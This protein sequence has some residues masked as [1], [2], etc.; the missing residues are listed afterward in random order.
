LISGAV[1]AAGTSSRM[2]VDKQTALLAGRPLIEYSIDSF[3]GSSVDE[4]VV[5]LGP[6]MDLAADIA[7]QKGARVLTNARAGLGMSTSLVLAVRSVGGSGLVVGLGDQ[8]LLLPRTIDLLVQAHAE[9]ARIS[10][11]TFNGR[12]GNPVLFDRSLF[13]ELLSLTGDVGAK[14]VVERHA[15]LARE[16]A[17]EDEGVLLDVDEPGD[18]ARAERLLATRSR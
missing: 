7:S 2:G 15:D 6:G 1:L 10:V 13:G 18:L 4:V 3:I 9:G 17:V 16:V 12:R 5:V 8:P 11:P 14:S